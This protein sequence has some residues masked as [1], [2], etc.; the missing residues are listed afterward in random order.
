MKRT[1]L[2]LAD[3]VPLTRRQRAQ[4]KYQQSAKG[5][6]AL[7]RYLAKVRDNPERK[8]KVIVR[9]NAWAMAHPIQRRVYKRTWQRAKARAVV[10]LGGDD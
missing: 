1:I 3:P 6:A 8:A 7:A 4:K 10:Q 2:L 9:V 5:K